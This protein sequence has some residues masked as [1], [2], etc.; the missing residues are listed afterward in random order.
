MLQLTF[1]EID[2]IVLSLG[3]LAIR[4][5]ALAYVTGILLGFFYLKHR[6]KSHPFFGA[7]ALDDLIL[8]AV[9]GIL[10]GGRLGYV[11]FYNADY[12]FSHP[13]EIWHIWQG[14]MA[15]H[16]GLIGVLIAYYLFARRF[17]LPYLSVLDHL[18][19][20]APL[21]LFF[22]RI[23]NFINGELVG[24]VASSDALITMVFPHVDALPRHPSQLYQ[25]L[26]EGL[27]LWIA[28]LLL[29]HRTKA[30]AKPGMVGGAFVLGYGILRFL[31]E[32]FREPDIQL[33]FVLGSLTMGQLLCIPMVLIGAAFIWRA[34]QQKKQENI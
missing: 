32:F 28:M 6:E 17:K 21:G 16:G 7:R 1:P 34:S 27:L 31:A 12:Y 24:R 4:W 15:F 18:A 20:V 10:L 14:G 30:L 19:I 33:G 13:L 23:A 5:Y 8:Y 11:L 22:G 26:G 25:A 2:P 9:L 29:A 3:P